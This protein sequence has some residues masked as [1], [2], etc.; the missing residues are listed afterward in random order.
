MPETTPLTG[1][2]PG[3]AYITVNDLNI[4]NELLVQLTDDDGIGTVNDNRVDTAIA[5]AQAE[6]DGYC[7]KR[8]KVPFTAP[9]RLV[10]R[11]VANLAAYNLY[12][13]RGMIAED[14]ASMRKDAIKTLENI[15]KGVVSLGMEPQPPPAAE[16]GG[17]ISGPKK[18]FGR[19]SMKGF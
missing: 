13:R 2:T 10:K 1:G 18:V 7:G 16:T 19:N 3:S 5:D 17:I 4:P 14:I 11:L 15:S 8:Y 6:V 12:A 9:T